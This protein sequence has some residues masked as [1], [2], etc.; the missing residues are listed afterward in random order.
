MGLQIEESK[1]HVHAGPLHLPRPAHVVGL[2]EAG[3][4]FHQRRHLLARLRGGDQRPRD[5]RVAAG[6][7]ERL[8][9]SQHT[10]IV[11]RT[12]HEIH[13]RVERFVGMMQQ[14]VTR[15]DGGEDVATT[16]VEAAGHPRDERLVVEFLEAGQLVEV[17]EGRQVER[18]VDPVDLAVA[19]GPAIMQVLG[20]D[21]HVGQR[22]VCLRGD[23]D[24]DRLAALPRLET[25]LDQPQHVV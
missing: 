1:Y 10:R 6:A 3:L 25:I 19:V 7:V 5:G 20:V 2:V 18:T 22:L 14:N 24:S 11:G 9:D 21:D 12:R 17:P 13:D 8:L 15:G 16:T 23:L 4:E